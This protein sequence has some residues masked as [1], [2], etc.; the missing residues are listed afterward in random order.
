MAERS[1]LG[2]LSQLREMVQ[3]PL[4]YEKVTKFR[5]ARSLGIV[6]VRA[7]L[8]GLTSESMRQA[9]KNARQKTYEHFEQLL[10]EG[11]V[12]LG[13]T[14]PNWDEE[15]APIDQIIIHHTSGKPG[16]RLS[17]LDAMHLLRLY[18]PVYQNPSA[19]VADQLKGKPIYSG[20]F[21]Q[22]GQQ[23]FRAYHWLVRQDGA[24]ERLLD[25]D[26]IGWHA[27]NWNV[28][29]QS[30]AICIDDDLTED[31][32]T[33]DALESV[34]QIIEDHYSQLAISP[35]TIRGHNEVVNTACP[36]PTFKDGW[37]NQLLERLNP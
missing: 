13:D 24:A 26:N 14:G 7:A 23:V 29:C 11:V 35:D 32:P 36:G 15:R 5:R 21:D 2:E 30:V 12:K 19:D 3:E 16:V 1:E 25:D 6:G 18:V 9:A 31:S 10:A 17:L 28:N 22:D 34:A 20:H 4:W 27:G 8:H 37:K 33:P